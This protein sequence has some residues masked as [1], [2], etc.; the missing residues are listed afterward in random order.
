MP[1]FTNSPLLPARS[2]SSESPTTTDPPSTQADQDRWA[3]LPGYQAG[4]I[5]PTSTA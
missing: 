4:L 1:T 3:D 5:D 2:S